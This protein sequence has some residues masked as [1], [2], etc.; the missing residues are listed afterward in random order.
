MT[1]SLLAPPPSGF[2]GVPALFTSLASLIFLCGDPSTRSNPAVLGVFIGS[3]LKKGAG[4][5]GVV[6]GG[7]PMQ[8]GF[9]WGTMWEVIVTLRLG[10]RLLRSCFP[11]LLLLG[12]GLLGLA[13][14]LKG[15]SVARVTACR[16]EMLPIV[17]VISAQEGQ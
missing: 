3:G 12:K 15:G 9:S 16:Q 10:T 7:G 5:P 4:G 2:D 14:S 17:N 11:R 8:R 1:T 13:G 6:H